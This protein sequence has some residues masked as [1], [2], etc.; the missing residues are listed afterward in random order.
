[1]KEW[2]E[3]L[4]YNT[5]NHPVGTLSSRD[6]I[7]IYQ[8]DKREKIYLDGNYSAEQLE[9]LARHMRKYSTSLDQ[10]STPTQHRLLN[11]NDIYN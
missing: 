8:P 7:V 1:M 10:K 4:K 6:P 9:V 5:S 2:I 11:D 3:K